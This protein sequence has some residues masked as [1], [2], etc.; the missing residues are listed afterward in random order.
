MDCKISN[1]AKNK[2]QEFTRL[3]NNLKLRMYFE[4]QKVRSIIV[5]ILTETSASLTTLTLETVAR[6]PE[7]NG[8]NLNGVPGK[9]TIC[10]QKTSGHIKHFLTL[11]TGCFFNLLLTRNYD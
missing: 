2:N 8:S 9:M 7:G 10:L 4:T 6:F 3:W 11:T 5:K 1:F